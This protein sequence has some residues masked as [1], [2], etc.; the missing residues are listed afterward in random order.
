MSQSSVSVMG[1]DPSLTSTGV[2]YMQGAVPKAYALG[3]PKLRGLSRIYR[4]RE[5]VLYHVDRVKPDL[6]VYEGYAMAGNGKVFDLG[7]LG[8]QLKM[9]ILLRGIDLL[10]VP[11]SNLKLFMAGKSRR[12]VDG[13]NDVK[14]GVQAE[15]DVQF[16]SSDQYDATGLLLMGEAYKRCRPLPRDRRHFK[17]RALSGC[18]LLSASEFLNSIAE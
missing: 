2:A 16:S 11:P 12:G 8:G 6:V 13:K 17:H 7:E 14:A 9:E 3:Y 1:I 5:A 18:Q 10:V 4:V 15:F